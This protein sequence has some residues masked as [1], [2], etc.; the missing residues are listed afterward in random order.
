MYVSYRIS[1]Y[2]L[3][4]FKGICSALF[5]NMVVENSKQ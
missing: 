4:V 2:N 3:S 1:E 5:V